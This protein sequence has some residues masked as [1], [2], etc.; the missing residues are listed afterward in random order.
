[1]TIDTPAR[2]ADQPARTLRRRV[3]LPGDPGY[4]AA[5]IPWNLAVDQRPAAVAIPH[6]ADEVADVV[7]AAAAAGLRVAPQ[8][9]GH[10]AAP[11]GAVSLDDV[12]IVRT[13]RS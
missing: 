5:R 11:L 2:S 6:S 7:R 3:H 8:S 9:T 1:M 12:V 10:A 4:D 13:S